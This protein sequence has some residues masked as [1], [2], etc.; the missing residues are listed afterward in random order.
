MSQEG[1]FII[2]SPESL[3]KACAGWSKGLDEPRRFTIQDPFTGDKKLIERTSYF[4]ESPE[5]TS[6]DFADAENA[7]STLAP[8]SMDMTFVGAIGE[9]Y[10]Y[11]PV[12]YY[13]CTREEDGWTLTYPMFELD[14][15]EVDEVVAEW[16]ETAPY[17]NKELRR[18]AGLRCYLYL[19]SY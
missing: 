9:L 4:P 13:L 1:Y 8:F 7:V 5:E 18:A 10:A 17:A 2:T 14:D 15:D 6:I 3:A 16:E 19:A 11:A 12:L